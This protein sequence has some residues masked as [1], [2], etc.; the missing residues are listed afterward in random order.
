MNKKQRQIATDLADAI[1]K[2]RE[3]D[4]DE[5]PYSSACDLLNETIEPALRALATGQIQRGWT[6]FKTKRK[7]LGLCLHAVTCT[8]RPKPGRPYCE[9]H[10]L[11]RN[12]YNREY[13]KNHKEYFLDRQRENRARKT[14]GGKRQ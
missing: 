9:T 5:S 12:E 6:A 14:A 8:E 1:A 10:R 3:N 13:Y 11:S 4:A 7:A 2:W